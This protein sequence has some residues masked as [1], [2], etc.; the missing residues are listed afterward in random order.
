M[1]KRLLIGFVLLITGC[2]TLPAVETQEVD[3]GVVSDKLAELQRQVET[4]KIENE[5]LKLEPEKKVS[6]KEQSEVEK[7]LKCSNGYTLSLDK[8]YCVKIP[9]N[10]HA[11]ESRTD[12]W[13]CND[14]FYESGKKCLPISIN[15][16]TP[17]QIIK[18]QVIPEPQ[19]ITTPPETQDISS[20]VEVSLLE[21]KKD[22]EK[23]LLYI[24]ATE[25]TMFIQCT[26]NALFYNTDRVL[27]IDLLGTHLLHKYTFHSSDSTPI[28]KKSTRFEGITPQFTITGKD[29]DHQ[30]FN[31][32]F[33]VSP[34]LS[35]IGFIFP[36]KE[37]S[38]VAKNIPILPKRNQLEF[39]PTDSPVQYD[40]F[41]SSLY[42]TSN[43]LDSLN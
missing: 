20:L 2:A 22:E 37:N 3:I 40:G 7:A 35:G 32:W 26:F 34:K 28:L 27:A 17:P 14:G 23:T 36:I 19:T 9:L 21:C 4:L 11:V 24:N 10:A 8:N 18:A 5:E 33:E 29:G 16:E 25:G 15:K 42:S 38:V 1:K 43:Y 31:L 12:V 39:L 30:T 6:F 41:A 13:L